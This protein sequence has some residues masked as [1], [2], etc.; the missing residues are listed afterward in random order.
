M[1]TTTDLRPIRDWSE[2]DTINF[3]GVSGVL[4]TKGTFV[5]AQGSGLNLLDSMVL[6]DQSWLSQT[7]SARFNVPNLTIPAT[8]GQLANKIIGMTVKT[9]QTFDEN[10][11]PL[12]WFPAKAAQLDVVI[13]GQAC[14]IIS[15]GDFLYSG[16]VTGAGTT[17]PPANGTG[18]GV[19]DA[20]DGSLQAVASYISV[21]GQGGVLS[22]VANPAIVATALGPIN[23]QGYCYIRLG[24]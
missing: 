22:Y 23:Q 7:T 3:F 11:L 13:S 9:V 8:S 17:A 4:V 19:S 2:H 10:G 14:P 21:S 6:T 15:E 18:L 24:L 20:G 5:Q 12:K 1:A 16:I